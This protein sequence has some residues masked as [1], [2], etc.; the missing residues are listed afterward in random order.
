MIDL[1][2]PWR[3]LL[4]RRRALAPSLAPYAEMLERW[5]A[6][7]PSRRTPGWSAPRCRESWSRG[8]PLTA[9]TPPPLDAGHLEDLLGAAMEEVAAVDPA[10][11][12]ALQR[13]A[14][15]WD[16]GAIGPDALLP[17]HDGIG[18]GRVET[19]TGLD[20]GAVAFLAYATLRPVLDA[21]LAPARPHFAEVEWGRGVCP[22]C[23]AP[24]G[25]VDVVEGGHRRLACHFCGGAWGFAKLRCP[26]CGVEGTKDLHRLQAEGEDAGYVITGCRGCRGYL[27]ELDRRERWNGGPP[28]LEDWASP[29]LDVVARREGFRKALPALLDLAR[30]S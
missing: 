1:R 23:G 6:W 9:E 3:D 2:D 7:T 25:F 29:H 24:P 13:L 11:A 26:L 20:A 16:A 19:A 30:A 28:L 4:A 18:D 14:G 10:R 5:A 17:R 21:W 15:A 22:F 8:V 27:K 12:P